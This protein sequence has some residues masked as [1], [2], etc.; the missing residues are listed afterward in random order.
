MEKLLYTIQEA[1][2][3]LSISVPSMYRLMRL[4][5]VTPVK[6]NGRTLFRMEELTRFA[7]EGYTPEKPAKEGAQ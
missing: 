4:K 7:R 3:M 6:L 1:A 2:E 5:A